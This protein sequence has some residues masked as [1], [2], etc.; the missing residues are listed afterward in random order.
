MVEATEKKEKAAADAKAA[1]D[2]AE[3]V[4]KDETKTSNT[5]TSKITSC[6][7]DAQ[8]AARKLES[9]KK[10]L[11]DLNTKIGKKEGKAKQ[12]EKLEEKRQ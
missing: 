7:R 1:K 5:I 4:K 3:K 8:F 10:D 9:L 11:D 6:K 2:T 12:V